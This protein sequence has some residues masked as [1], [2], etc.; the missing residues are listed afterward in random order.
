MQT[1][2][3]KGT[4]L[5]LLYRADGAYLEVEGLKKK[6]QRPFHMPQACKA[7]LGVCGAL[8]ASQRIQG[9]A[10]VGVQGVK[11]LKSQR[12][13][14]ILTTNFGL[15]SNFASCCKVRCKGASRLCSDKK[16]HRIYICNKYQMF[17][18]KK[19]L[20]QKI[21]IQASGN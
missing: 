12:P 15:K 19:N 21:S 11:P 1:Q 8:G 3:V 17:F 14:S 6:D 7:Q 18:L 9:R 4:I 10:L 16:K 20:L 2:G 5:Y 13:Q